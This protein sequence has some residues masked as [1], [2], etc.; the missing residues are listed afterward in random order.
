MNLVERQM[1]GILVELKRNYGARYVRAE[2]EAEGLRVEELLRLKDISLRSSMGLSLKIGGCEGMRDL[3]ESKV[4]GADTIVAPMIESAFALHKYEQAAFK[5]YNEEECAYTHFWFNM[6][7][8]SAASAAVDIFSSAAARRM[9]AAVIE[10]VDLS[11]SLGKGPDHVD[12]R[13]ISDIVTALVHLAKANSIKTV[14]GGGVSL[15][16]AGLI[17]SFAKD[18]LLDYYESRK[19][20][21]EAVDF[22]KERYA[23]GLLLAIAF[24]VF[25]LKNKTQNAQ[26][27]T[28]R[29]IARLG[30]LEMNYWGDIKNILPAIA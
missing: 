5:V 9:E 15:R 27:A 10:R 21:F 2:F 16:S 18:G 23:Q 7:T 3:I 26:R 12:D 11:F 22:T 24:E 17:E 1:L 30:Y 14:L 8:T 4:I 28:E 6:E 25:F 29:D 13:D 19:V 20:G